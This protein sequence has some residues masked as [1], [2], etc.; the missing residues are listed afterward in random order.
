MLLR[1]FSSTIESVSDSVSGP[2]SPA[3]YHSKTFQNGK[4]P[5]YPKYAP[6]AVKTVIEKYNHWDF[7]KYK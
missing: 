1:I 6:S 4:P 7:V 3:D 5:V 2:L